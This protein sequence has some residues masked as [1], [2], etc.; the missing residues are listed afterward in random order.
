MP[1]SLR[2]VLARSALTKQR[3]WAQDELPDVE[4][5]FLESLTEEEMRIL[6]KKY[7]SDAKVSLPCAALSAS[8][9]AFGF[10]FVSYRLC[11][12][13]CEEERQEVQEEQEGEEVQEGQAQQAQP[14]RKL[15]QRQQQRQQ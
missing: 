14:Q 7:K 11:R 12:S 15:Q 2:L 9:F 5:Q 1:A 6:L 13:G 10:I 8:V 4:Q 3:C